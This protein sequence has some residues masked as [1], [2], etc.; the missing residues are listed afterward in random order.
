MKTLLKKLLLFTLAAAMCAAAPLTALAE[1]PAEL[2]AV[3]DAAMMKEGSVPGH[4]DEG[5]ET[6]LIAAKTLIGIDDELYTDFSYS[7]SYSNYEAME[8][9]IWS[10]NWT[11]RQHSYVYASVSADG[12]LLSFYSYDSMAGEYGMA[13]I[14]KAAA[15]AAAKDFIKAAN[16]GTY[17]YYG[18]PVSVD[19]SLGSQ[20]YYISFYANQSGYLFS[21]SQIGVQV[22]KITGKVTGYST[23][24]IDP[25]RFEFDDAMSLISQDEAIAAYAEKI[26][27][28]LEYFSSF[29]YETNTLNVYPAYR[30]NSSG[31]R[32]INAITG[33][34][35]LFSYDR[36]TAGSAA[37]YS[38]AGGAASDASA[39]AAKAENEGAASLSP[40]ELSAIEQAGEFITGE[41]ALLNLLDS[42]GLADLDVG[43]FN[44]KYISLNR[45]YI[46][47]D[48]YCYDVSLYRYGAPLEKG[49]QDDITGLYGRVDA[50]T[51]RVLSFS[52]YSDYAKFPTATEAILSLEE[53]QALAD[54]FLAKEAPDEL[55][56]SKQEPMEE[57]DIAPYRYNGGNYSFTYTRLANGI[58]FRN[59]GIYVTVN[60]VT[61]RITNYNLNWYS[62]VE[63]PDVSG[64]LSAVDALTAYAAQ[65][66]TNLIY[67]TIGG[68]K[69][70]LV[71]E[72][73]GTGII[74]PFT[75]AALDYLGEP[76]SD[77][78]IVP[79]YSDIAGHWCETTVQTLLDNG[80]RLWSGSFEPEK[81]MT[82]LEFLR[83][84]MQAE[85]YARYYDVMPAA[86][87]T[88]RHINFEVDDDMILTR[89]DAV[90]IITLYLGY[91]LLAEQ[92]EWFVY[93]FS[94]DVAEEFRGY[95]TI[96]YMLG[97][98]SGNGAG[99]F[100]AGNNVT[101]AQA[102]V[103]VYNLI[104]V[105]GG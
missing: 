31:D 47:R 61:G 60:A 46:N 101:R 28:E 23:S 27:L 16:P 5:M 34:V 82:Q 104:Q 86:Y 70:A 12:T 11:D 48:R 79:E 20:A 69:A 91:G 73:K 62:N 10:F 92:P 43:S 90:K 51:G 74:D 81:T 72:F 29:D 2:Q 36:A 49:D 33:E 59:N 22:N 56:M 105:K 18:E 9:L 75:G 13:L 97:I 100:G 98:V 45:D 39:P 7:S 30:L 76:W 80:V 71:Y 35:V 103:M 42:A 99:S 6:A 93:P 65:N 83:L 64:A 25:G 58:S 32:F 40:A 85:P 89:Q 38:G 24:N 63:F 15:T 102:A 8:G 21:A 96:C 37:M 68:G 4:A 50:M 41:Q 77:A 54:A 66:G 26:G 44:D 78:S 1:G 94:D 19:V 95:V 14:G 88:E 84:L 87:F 55:A 67:T 57:W 53:A 17:S 52:Y 3:T